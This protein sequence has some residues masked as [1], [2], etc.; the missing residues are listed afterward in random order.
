MRIPQ[1]STLANLREQEADKGKKWFFNFPTG[2]VQNKEYGL[3]KA[4]PQKDCFFQRGGI[5]LSSPST[6]IITVALSF[7]RKGKK[8][9]K[10][11]VTVLRRNWSPKSLTSA[12]KTSTSD[13][14]F[15]PTD[16]KHQSARSLRKQTSKRNGLS[17][18]VILEVGPWK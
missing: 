14:F 8:A 1:F 12:L 15:K 13:V 3:K 5:K 16:D 11:G 4:P 10:R 9:K 18:R 7:Q 6:K 2:L 17:G